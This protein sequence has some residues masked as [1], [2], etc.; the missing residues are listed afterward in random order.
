[1]CSTSVRKK[2]KII[3]ILRGKAHYHVR[4][5]P[6]QKMLNF[7][8]INT[9]CKSCIIQ[10]LL[11]YRN[12][13][14]C[15]LRKIPANDLNK[16]LAGLREVICTGPPMDTHT[17]SSTHLKTQR[18]A[19]FFGIFRHKSYKQQSRKR[20]SSS[21]MPKHKPE[22]AKRSRSSHEQEVF[23]LPSSSSEDLPHPAK[24]RIAPAASPR[25]KKSKQ[26]R[27]PKLVPVPLIIPKLT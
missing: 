26:K 20:L 18:S 14:I 8:F 27:K 7:M 6:T 3:G 2:F 16:A 4:Y 21:N 9:I 22:V 24:L 10:Q 25:V 17:L 1:M 12:R 11:F 15:K 5:L 13:R 19:Q 23:E